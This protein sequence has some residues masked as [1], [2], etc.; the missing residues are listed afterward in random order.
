[1][2]PAHTLSLNGLT[3]CLII[4]NGYA[5]EYMLLLIPAGAR[6]RAQGCEGMADSCI[7]PSSPASRVTSPFYTLRWT[8]LPGSLS[9]DTQMITPASAAHSQDHFLWLVL[10]TGLPWHVRNASALKNSANSTFLNNSWCSRL[11]PLP[12]FFMQTISNLFL[13]SPC[14]LNEAHRKLGKLKPVVY[15]S[16][17]FFLLKV[18]FVFA[19]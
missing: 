8:H 5:M 2:F 18:N 17:L 15:I 6:E 4:S 1:M 11:S 9:R 7:N 14:F 19:S 3:A 12:L 16:Y 13:I 10:H